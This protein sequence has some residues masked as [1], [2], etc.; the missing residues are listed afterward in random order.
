MIA[1]RGTGYNQSMRSGESES[2]SFDENPEPRGV[3]LAIRKFVERAFGRLLDK[4]I[5]AIALG[6]AGFVLGVIAA[7]VILGVRA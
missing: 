4:A 7:S 2:T 6:A 1:Q 3:R 5:D